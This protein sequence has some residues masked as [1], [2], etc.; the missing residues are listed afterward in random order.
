M[1]FKRGRAVGQGMIE[2]EQQRVALFI[3]LTHQRREQPCLTVRAGG[4]PQAQHIAYQR[5]R[6]GTLAR[7]FH[8]TARDPAQQARYARAKRR[9]S[10]E[11]EPG[12]GVLFQADQ[13]RL[14]RRTE[15]TVAQRQSRRGVTEGVHDIDPGRIGQ[16]VMQ[17]EIGIWLDARHDGGRAGKIAR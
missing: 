7:L 11:I 5:F 1:D 4:Q 17:G 12:V 2:V 16:A 14:Q 3:H 10:R 13:Q 15:L 6:A 8:H 9:T